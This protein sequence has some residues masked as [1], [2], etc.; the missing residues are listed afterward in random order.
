MAVKIEVMVLWVVTLCS[1]A[2]GFR[3]KVEAARFSEHW[4]PTATLHS[5]TT[6]KTST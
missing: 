6:K 2:S 1:V 3:V 5:I 4:C